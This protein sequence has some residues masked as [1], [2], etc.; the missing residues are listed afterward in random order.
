MLVNTEIAYSEIEQTYRHCN[1][2]FLLLSNFNLLVSALLNFAIAL[3]PYF[4]NMFCEGGLA[5]ATIDFL[6]STAAA[7]SGDGRIKHML[8]GLAMRGNSPHIP[9]NFFCDLRL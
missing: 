3:Y 7:A 5:M 1:K 6:E 2:G 8:T 9:A 4:A